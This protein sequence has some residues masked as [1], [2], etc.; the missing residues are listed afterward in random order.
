MAVRECGSATAALNQL[1]PTQLF[2]TDDQQQ[3]RDEAMADVLRWEKEGL[4]FLT[5]LDA[6]Y[7]SR[8]RDIHQAPPFLFARGLIRIS[9]P[10]VS[11]VGSRDASTRGLQM[12]ASIATAVAREGLTVI[13][14]LAAGVDSA[15]HRAALDADGRTVAMIGTG[16]E[17]VYPAANRALQGE[18]AERGLVL[19][20]FWPDA[21]PQKF[22]F[23]MR[24]ATMSGYGL[25][26]I[27]VEAGE[28]SGAR[29]QARMAVEHGRRVILTDLVERSTKWGSE[30]VGRPGVYVA[31]STDDVMAAVRQIRDRESVSSRLLAGLTAIG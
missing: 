17:K 20:Q 29:A 25:A 30:L 4:T 3:L 19:S 11:V 14:G 1:D 16:I 26:T 10:G 7:P 15:A 12:A 5:I 23:L 22:T 9:D 18:I 28:H 21:P 24:N 31:S 27:V 6:A 2:T 8:V 13:S